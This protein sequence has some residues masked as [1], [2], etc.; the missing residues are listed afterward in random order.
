MHKEPTKKHVSIEI[1]IRNS[2]FG[3]KE[4]TQISTPPTLVQTNVGLIYKVLANMYY[5]QG[6]IELELIHIIL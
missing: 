2:L 4:P 6:Y 3:K 1:E 5:A